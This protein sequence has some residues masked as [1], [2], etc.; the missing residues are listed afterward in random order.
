MLRTSTSYKIE[1]SK[2]SVKEKA[3]TLSVLEEQLPGREENVRGAEQELAQLVSKLE[4]G[5]RSLQGIRSQYE[6]KKNSQKN[7]KRRLKERQ[8]LVRRFQT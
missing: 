1:T 6:E 5:R 2:N 8:P 7:W 4:K 3:A